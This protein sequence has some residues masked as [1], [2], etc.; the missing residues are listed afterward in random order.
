M[1]AV[2]TNTTAQA[3]AMKGSWVELKSTSPF[4]SLSMAYAV[5]EG[6]ESRYAR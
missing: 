1:A 2:G 5:P 3:R 4:V 6:N